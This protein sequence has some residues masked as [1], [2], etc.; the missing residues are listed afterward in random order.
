MLEGEVR[1]DER[2]LDL[3]GQALVEQGELEAVEL[4]AAVQVLC[5]PDDGRERQHL[6]DLGQPVQVVVDL[7]DPLDPAWREPVGR[8]GGHV[9][10]PVL[11]VLLLVLQLCY[12]LLFGRAIEVEQ[13]LQR[14]GSP[15]LLVDELHAL[16]DLGIGPEVV[17]EAVLDGEPGDPDPADDHQDDRA[18]QHDVPV[19]FRDG[20]KPA[21]HPQIHDLAHAGPRPSQ[22]HQR[23]RKQREGG[24]EG[25]CQ[26]GAHHPAEVLH[27]LDAAEHE[28]AEPDDGREG[29][30]EARPDHSLQS[31]R[32]QLEVAR[33]RQVAVQL[34]VP[35]RQVDVHG[36]R[37]DQHQRQEVRRDDGHIPP[38]Q[39]EDP[40]HGHARVEAAKQGKNHPPQLSKDHGQHDD[41]ENEHAHSER[42]QVAPHEAD[43]VVRDHGRPAKVQTCGPAVPADHRSHPLDFPMAPLVELLVHLAVRGRYRLQHPLVGIAQPVGSPSYEELVA[44]VL[45]RRETLVFLQVDQQRRGL[46]VRADQLSPVNRAVDELLAGERAV[47]RGRLQSLDVLNHL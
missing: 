18:R 10:V 19:A 35:D 28:R 40:D 26:P 2:L 36:D 39:T 22:Q 47:D 25:H 33:F 24:Q 11:E 23:G 44:C 9:D 6:A 20:S 5:H 43:H 42:D 46:H 31:Q 16:V 32:D 37:N 29:R 34:P 4:L 27:G 8:R 3:L 41:Q 17:D 21:R 45:K 7:L 1:I 15:E 14:R 38:D 30:V 13:D 12:L